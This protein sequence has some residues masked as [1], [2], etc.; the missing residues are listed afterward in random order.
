[1]KEW[2][3]CPL[4]NSNRSYQAL[5]EKIQE[6]AKERA[7]HAITRQRA[8]G[9]K[10][11]DLTLIHFFFCVELEE[12]LDRERNSW[13]EREKEATNVLTTEQNLRDFIKERMRSFGMDN[14]KNT[15]PK[16]LKETREVPL[17][18]ANARRSPSNPLPIFKQAYEQRTSPKIV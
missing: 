7:A 4:R 6:L 15:S 10:R 8:K 1:L 16:E 13:K 3:R 2:P 9:T 11:M 14:T 18:T 17:D 5:Q 12:T